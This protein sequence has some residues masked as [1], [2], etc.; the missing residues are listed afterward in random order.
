MARVEAVGQIC[1]QLKSFTYYLGDAVTETPS[2]SLE[3]ATRT[4]ACRMRTKRYLRELYDQSKLAL[5][6]ARIVKVKAIEALLPTVLT[7]PLTPSR[8]LLIVY[9]L[10]NSFPRC[11]TKETRCE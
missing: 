2:I 8:T 11:T 4:H 5:L 3:I 10:Y 7:D 6:K 9:T 1:K